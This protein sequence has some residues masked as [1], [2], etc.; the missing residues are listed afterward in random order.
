VAW[1]AVPASGTVTGRRLNIKE[2]KEGRLMTTLIED[3]DF[4]SLLE[5][6]E[7]VAAQFRLWS[8][9]QGDPGEPTCQELDALCEV[10]CYLVGGDRGKCLYLAKFWEPAEWDEVGAWLDATATIFAAEIA[11]I[12]WHVDTWDDRFRAA[13]GPPAQRDAFRRVVADTIWEVLAT[14]NRQHLLACY[15][16][17]S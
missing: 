9:A 17:R 11:A 8:A 4:P 12:K 3:V 10:L 1:G 14:Q 15:G 2:R 5:L 7:R 16:E 13:G 6:R